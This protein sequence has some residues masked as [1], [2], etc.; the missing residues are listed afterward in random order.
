LRGSGVAFLGC[1]DKLDGEGLRWAL[2]YLLL[3][4][5]LLRVALGGR[6]GGALLLLPIALVLVEEGF[7][8]LLPRSELCGN[9][10][11][12]VGLG[13]GLAT[14]LADQVP[15]GGSSKECLNDVGVGDVGELSALLRKPVNVLVEAFVRLLPAVWRSQEF[16]GR[17]YVP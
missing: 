7:D 4:L 12:F 2:L 1:G 6:L 15:T 10:H 16:H 14:Q 13:Q 3:L 8:L 17:T 11:Q 9:V 5:T